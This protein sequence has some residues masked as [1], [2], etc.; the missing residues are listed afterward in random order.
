MTLA[1]FGVIVATLV[2]GA[3]GAVLRAALVGRSARSGTAVANIVGTL[4][5]A[6]VLVAHGRGMLGDG[7]AVA[8]A[9]GLSGSLTTFSGWIGIVADGLE[10][11]AATTLLVDV[12]LPLLTAVGITVLVFALLA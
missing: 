1:T 8:L 3:V 4:A 11:R 5:L 9:V 12:L 2:A 6:L 7:A 10:R